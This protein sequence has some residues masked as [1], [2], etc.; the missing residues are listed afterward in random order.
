MMFESDALEVIQFFKQR[1]QEEQ[2]EVGDDGGSENVRKMQ[3]KLKALSIEQIF[4]VKLIARLKND[5]NKIL[6]PYLTSLL[7][8]PSFMYD[9]KKVPPSKIRTKCFSIGIDLIK[10]GIGQFLLKSDEIELYD[11][12]ISNAHLLTEAETQQCVSRILNQFCVATPENLQ[13]LGRSLELLSQLAAAR[14]DD[15]KVRNNVITQLLTP[16][17]EWPGRAVGMLASCLVELVE[18]E[19]DCEEALRKLGGFVSWPPGGTGTRAGKPQQQGGGGGGG[20]G[21]GSGSSGGC[22]NDS[23][24]IYAASSSSESP[25]FSDIGGGRGGGGGGDSSASSPRIASRI[26]KAETQI[27]PE[28]LPPLF[29]QMT[30]LSKKMENGSAYLKSIVVDAIVKSLDLLVTQTNI[31]RDQGGGMTGSNHSVMRQRAKDVISTIVHHLSILVSKDQGISAEI[32]SC[33]KNR[34]LLL[35]QKVGTQSRGDSPPAST[36]IQAISPARLLLC[37]LAARAPRLEEKLNSALCD[38]L[39]EVQTVVDKSSVSMW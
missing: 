22:D 2:E 19:G 10:D 1:R 15:A 3:C 24:D 13:G 37:M 34:R 20:G 28:E 14:P 23:L 4:E 32:L 21:V 11:T 8:F 17:R 29:Y 35:R 16:A 12:L 38:V 30:L 5:K 6:G 9:I 36:V 33:V 27:D 7:S 18:S 25:I 39:V 26:S 31:Y